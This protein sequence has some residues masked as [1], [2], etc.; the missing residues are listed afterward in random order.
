MASCR[1]W[2]PGLHSPGTSTVRTRATRTPAAGPSITTL[3]SRPLVVRPSITRMTWWWFMEFSPS[4]A[5]R[6]MISVPILPLPVA[7]TTPIP[8]VAMEV[9]VMYPVISWRQSKN[10]IGWHNHNGRGYKTHPDRYPRSAVKGSPEPITSVQTIPVAPVEIKTCHI[11]HQIDIPCSARNHHH[12]RWPCKFQ[13]RRRF[14]SR[15][16]GWRLFLSRR[17]RRRN[18]NIDV[19]IRSCTNKRHSNS[20]KKRNHK[21]HDPLHKMVLLS[22]DRN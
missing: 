14:W 2:A 7:T 13:R 5:M 22:G 15:L 20:K 8:P 18:V 9:I 11:W 17:R 12:I 6:G 1:P 16:Y 10:I 19:H 4:P 21:Q 3:D